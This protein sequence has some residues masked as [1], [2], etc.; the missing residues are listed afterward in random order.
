[1]QAQ[2]TDELVFDAHGP[3]E[4]PRDLDVAAIHSALEPHLTP[5]RM[6]RIRAVVAER[7][8][9][10]APV[11]DRIHDPHNASAIMRSADA[12]GIQRLHIIAEHGAFLANQK[13]AKGTERWL[14][15]VRYESPEEAAAALRKDGYR[16]FIAAMD[17]E[18]RPET[19]AEAGDRI[20]VVFGNE[21]RGVS[22]EFRALADGSFAI[23]MLG[24]VESLNVSV[25]AAVTLYTLRQRLHK[26][27][28]E[29]ERAILEARMM[30]SSSGSSAEAILE[31][32]RIAAGG[33]AE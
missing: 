2:E 10:I 13:V 24:F 9:A 4:L 23:P 22:P 8:L 18:H 5:A 16:I 17:G 27:L 31:R 6:E 1:M 33:R 32:S 21:H 26:P 3:P 7:T 15:L 14:D 30:L 25:A 29:E 20:A 28:S 19:L 11:L 12:F